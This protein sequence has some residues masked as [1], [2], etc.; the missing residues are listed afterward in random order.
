MFAAMLGP[1]PEDPATADFRPIDPLRDLEKG[2]E[3]LRIACIVDEDLTLTTDEVRADL[4]QAAATLEKLGARVEPFKMP[5][6][7]ESYREATGII[8]AS[9]GYANWRKLIDDPNSGMA[10]PI[11]KRFLSA[12][13]VN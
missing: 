4:A 2:V 3:G 5:R 9:E 13:N 11:R 12:R 8:I 1:D 6:S 10:D 7:I